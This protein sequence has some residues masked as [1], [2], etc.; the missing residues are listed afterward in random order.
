VRATTRLTNSPACIV[1]SDPDPGPFVTQRLSSSLL[2]AQPVLEIDPQH[3]LVEWLHHQPD[4][5]QLTDSAHVRHHQAVLTLGARINDPA[6]FADHL[7]NLLITLAIP[8]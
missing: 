3:P 5:P 1:A 6:T 2:P 7:N 4:D 8:G